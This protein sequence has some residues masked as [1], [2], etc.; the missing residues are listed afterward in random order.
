MSTISWSLHFAFQFKQLEKNTQG[1]M[2]QNFMTKFSQN[3]K[4]SAVIHLN[5]RLKGAF[6][7]DEVMQFAHESREVSNNS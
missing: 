7:P 1:V 6:F 3:N 2:I 4:V 5:L